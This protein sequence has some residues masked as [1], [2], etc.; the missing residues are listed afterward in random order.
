MVSAASRRR[1]FASSSGFLN[2]MSS[3]ISLG[4]G[5]WRS[6]M[7]WCTSGLGANRAI[8]PNRVGCGPVPKTNPCPPARLEAGGAKPGDA[9]L[10]GRIVTDSIE[11]EE[12]Y[13]ELVNRNAV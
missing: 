2:R 5:I 4:F 6:I 12:P 3:K 1:F 13:L 10:T 7:G 9:A 11:R 8:E